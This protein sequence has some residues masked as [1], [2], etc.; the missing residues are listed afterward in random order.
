MPSASRRHAEPWT[1][2]GRRILSS[3]GKPVA[4]AIYPADA[5]RIVLV[6]NSMA[7]IPT[8]A[9]ERASLRGV[10]SRLMSAQKSEI[11]A[12]RRWLDAAG[13]QLNRPKKAHARLS[14]AHRPPDAR[15]LAA[16]MNAVKG[17][18]TGA[19]ESEP[20]KRVLAAVA[21]ASP[22]NLRAIE[23]WLN[24]SRNEPRRRGRVSARYG[25]EPPS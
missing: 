23:K 15:R 20:V 13:T 7:G 22:A 5:R 12:V 3:S 11:D 21:L 24:A 17:V 10:V 4:T 2:D 25:P 18:P 1:R 16:A 19:L 9:L 8:S 6:I 14:T